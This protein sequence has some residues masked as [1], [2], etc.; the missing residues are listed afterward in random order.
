VEFDIDIQ[1]SMDYYIGYQATL[2]FSP[3]LS[4]LLPLP[5][6]SFPPL[7]SFLFSSSF[8]FFFPFPFLPFLLLFSFF[9][10]SFSPLFPPSFPSFSL[11]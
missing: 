11:P 8:L 5:L 10:L 1:F 9:L 4:P 7:S 2:A 3:L 6:F